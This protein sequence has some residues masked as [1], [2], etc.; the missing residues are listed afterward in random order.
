MLA[1]LTA[2]KGEVYRISRHEPSFRT[3]NNQA[4]TPLADRHVSRQPLT[5]RRVAA[6]T[7]EVTRP[8]SPMAVSVNG[9]LIERATTVSL[10]ELGEDIIICL[11]DRIIL[12]IFETVLPL[13]TDAARHGLIG[14]SKG[15]QRAWATVRQGA[16]THLPMLLT[17]ATGTGK[18]LVASAIHALS[19][20][21]AQK[22]HTVNMAALSPSLAHAELFGA[23][24]G[25]YTGATVARIGLFAQAH[26][27]TLFMDEIG[28]APKEVQPMLLRALENGEYRRLGDTKAQVADVRIISATDRSLEAG[29]FN[30][31]LRH[32]LQGVVVHL[33][34]LRDRRVDIGLLLRHFLTRPETNLGSRDPATVPAGEVLP[35]LLHPWPGN[36]RELAGA[37]RQ[38]RMGMPVTLK[39][40]AA[41][42]VN[43]MSQEP[44][45]VAPSPT[46]RRH[47]DPATVDDAEMVGALTATEWNIK[48]AAMLLNVSRT[49]LYRLMERSPSLKEPGLLSADKVKDD[50][51]RRTNDGHSAWASKLK[52]SGDSL[53]RHLRRSDMQ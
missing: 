39:P 26:G 10:D 2:G 7:V 35:L 45:A 38:M 9:R 19:T 13:Q 46:A 37:A 4:Q 3:G 42:A 49:S 53:R 24:A 41:R 5:I 22:L 14:I 21:S 15:L 18:E 11:S 44:V 33:P 12:S 32:R 16:P 48:A 17:G 30:Q 23:T 8:D 27:G 51:H 50:M 29:D 47:R 43:E 6:R 34:P 40:V 36:I 1:P 31:P 28:D 52:P 25:A 20:R